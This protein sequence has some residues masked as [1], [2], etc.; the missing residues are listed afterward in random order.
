MD[1]NLSISQNFLVNNDFVNELISKS[2]INNNDLV[3]EIG[4]GKGI[5]TE[6]LAKKAKEII[7]IEFDSRLALNLKVKFEDYKNVKI[8]NEDFLRYILPNKP[9]KVFSNLPFSLSADILNKLLKFPN[10]MS[11][12]YLI[13]QDKTVER[14]MGEGNQISTLWKPF[15]EI[16]ILQ[17]ISKNEFRPVPKVNIV[18][19]KFE[20]RK[21]P[22]IDVANYQLYRDFVIYGYNQWKPT[23]LEAFSKLFTKEQL[24]IISKKCN[25]DNLKP[26]ETKINQ[27]LGLFDAF[28][29]HVLDKKKLFVKGY[30]IKQINKQKDMIKRHRTNT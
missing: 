7:A 27:W 1:N 16:S 10:T 24:K 20:K 18:F 14:F 3:I 12:A 22:M 8:L 26:S 15:Y 9:F 4:S 21:T 19:C 30:E 25:L 11:E 28:Q 2:S 23:L 6:I 17:K 5:I 13:L 29:N